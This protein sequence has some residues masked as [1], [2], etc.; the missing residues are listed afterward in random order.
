MALSC[1][2]RFTF[3]ERHTL[4]LASEALEDL[5]PIGGSEGQGNRLSLNDLNWSANENSNDY[6]SLV[7]TTTVA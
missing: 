6:V 4:S 7:V 2:K 5:I 1:W 3:F